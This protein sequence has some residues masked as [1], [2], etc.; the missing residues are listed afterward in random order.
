[1][2]NVCDSEKLSLN[3]SLK[4]GISTN[5]KRVKVR[6]RTGMAVTNQSIASGDGV[7]DALASK[8]KDFSMS[9]INMKS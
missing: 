3:T 8:S 5:R 9:S 1:M 4:S 2:L 6:V 7:L